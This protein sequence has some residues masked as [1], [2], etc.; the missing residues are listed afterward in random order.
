[1]LGKLIKYEL[2]GL[3]M[4]LLIMLIVLASTTALTCG[5]IITINPEQT[6]TMAWYSVM[7]LMVSVFLYYFGIIGCSLGV[8]LTI[9]VRF[10]KTCYTDQ[11]YLT[12]TLPVP[13][14]TILNAKI[15][16]AII[17]SLS[18]ILAVGVSL[19]FIAEAVIHIVSIALES[20]YGSA[21]NVHNMIHQLLA[22]ISD[23]FHDTLGIS[24]GMYIVYLLVYVIISTAA[25]IVIMLGCVSLG[26]L[27]AKH[28]IIG[29]I[30]AYFVVQ[31]VLQ[32][33]GYIAYTPMYTRII[34]DESFQNNPSVFSA[35]SPTLN[36]ILVLTSLVAVGMYFVNLHMMTKRLNLE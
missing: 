18:T 14:H 25:G 31:F 9:V 23:V 13:P 15:L 19:V 2:K 3:R 27:Y 11:G 5:I 10:Y 20:E 22:E 1:M 26:Q 30:L 6:N 24:V 17:A 35:M 34:F 8:T 16:S 29:A 4:P 12:H 21:A 33:I 32:I 28:R 7:M 36:I